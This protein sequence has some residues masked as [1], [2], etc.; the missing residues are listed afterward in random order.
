[1]IK[2]EWFDPNKSFLSLKI[3]WIAVFILLFSAVLSATIIIIHSKLEL[4]LSYLGFN[5]FISIFKFPLAITALIIPIVA[6]LAANH[7]SEQTKEQIRVTNSQNVFSNYYKHIEEFVKYSNGRGDRDVDLRYAHSNIYP[8]A[9]EGNYEINMILIEKLIN[10]DKIPSDII[11][12]KPT[13]VDEPPNDELMSM[14]YGLI[15]DIYY[16]IF[17]DRNE[18]GHHITYYR[19]ENYGDSYLYHYKSLI[20]HARNL[21][22]II[23]DYCKFSVDF[24]SQNKVLTSQCLNMDEVYIYKKKS[25]AR[26]LRRTKEKEE[27]TLEEASEIFFNKLD[28]AIK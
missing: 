2:S 17:R 13:S 23:E 8:Y 15:H 9:S 1:M 3:V 27:R 5:S 12:H 6:L 26:T 24:I 18:F 14:Y 19:D 25:E 22:E 11:S 20:D 7:R 10:L 16:L 21:I 28:E 4:N